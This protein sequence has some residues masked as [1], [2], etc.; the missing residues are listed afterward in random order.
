MAS[1]VR[2][3]VVLPRIGT[4][5]AKFAGTHKRGIAMRTV[6]AILMLAAANACGAAAAT[7]NTAAVPNGAHDFDFEYGRWQVHH[8]VK[9]P[10]SGEW[11]EFDGTC[12]DRA[13]VDGSAN[14]EEHL[15]HRPTGDSYGIAMRA[16]DTKTAQWAI[17]WV[18]GRD[19]HGTLDPPVKGSFVD[20]VGTFYSDY[21]DHGKP[22]RVRYIWSHITPRAARW[23]QALTG[24]G[25]KTWTTNWIMEFQRVP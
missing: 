17:W 14:V 11:Y 7:D 21:V 12:S 10:D 24:D 18:D 1:L 25:G 13:L 3:Q 16:Y 4:A 23:E 6:I 9:R 15:F 8:R 19:P 2:R 20:G 5:R 22:M